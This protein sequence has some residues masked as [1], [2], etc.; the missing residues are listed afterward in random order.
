MNKSEMAKKFAGKYNVTRDMADEYVNGVLQL[1]M[2]G[3]VLDDEHRVNLADFGVFSLKVMKGHA[4]KN[5]ATQ[6]PIMV[7]DHEKITF[8]PYG[9]LKKAL[10]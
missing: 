8:K 2:D 6:E 3:V 9:A 1:I 5:P 7:P 4:A 10:M